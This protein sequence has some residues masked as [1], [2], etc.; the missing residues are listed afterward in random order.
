MHCSR[1][2]VWPECHRRTR[3]WRR[4]PDYA[5]ADFIANIGKAFT[6]VVSNNGAELGEIVE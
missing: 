1:P 5:E 6:P 3:R 4:G 2:R